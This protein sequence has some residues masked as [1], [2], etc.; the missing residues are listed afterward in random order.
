MQY[1][2]GGTSLA[3]GSL[4]RLELVRLEQDERHDGVRSRWRCL[5]CAHQLVDWCCSLR[6]QLVS[7]PLVLVSCPDSRP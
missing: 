5:L 7:P 2:R 3:D 1:P 4:V 6:H